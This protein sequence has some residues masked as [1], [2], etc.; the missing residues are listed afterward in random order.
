MNQKQY[1]FNKILISNR[2]EIAS[3]IIFTCKALGIKTVAI[4]SPEDK[5]M[6]YVYQADKAYELSGNGASAYLDQDEIIK[7]A[8]E[9]KV[10]AIHPGYGFF[11][12]N[13]KFAQ[14]VID[15][16]I[17]WI[18]PD[19][20]SIKLMGDKTEARNTMLK[21]NVPVIPGFCLSNNDTK[22]AQ[23]IALQIGY[24]IILKDPLGGGGKA[25]RKVEEQK[26]FESC[27]KIVKSE[28]ERFTGSN[29]IIIEK[30]IKN[31]RHIEI[32]VAGDGKNFI[33]LYERECSIQRRHQKII[34]ETPCNF[35]SKET[36][37]K[38]YQT[39]IYAAKAVNYKNI[40]T[41]E[42]IVTPDQNF[43][44]LE[45][46]TRL[47]VEHSITE[48]TTGIDLV[49]LQLEIAQ[50]GKLPF[51]Q[52]E[53][54]Q[55]SHAIECRIYSEDPG[56]NFAPSTGTIKNLQLPTGPFIRNDH[57]LEENQ[58]ITP[59]FDPMISKLTTVGSNR[60][61]A[62]KNMLN[63]LEQFNISG[64]KTNIEFLKNILKSEKFINGEFHTQ[65]LNDPEYLKNL[66][67]KSPNNPSQEEIAKIIF[68]LFK[69]QAKTKPK[70]CHQTNNNWRNQKWQ[71]TKKS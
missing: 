64:I 66:L 21:A 9:A 70:H 18:G 38:M 29:K 40:G 53:I 15:S 28:S 67:N 45:M 17:S 8:L 31:G 26:D 46:N 41:V 35:L 32:Q 61:F 44:F 65:T 30:Y 16:K 57:N 5:F 51:K 13:Y 19:P 4:Y 6:P 34:E 63:A 47:Q 25:I 20:Q 24:P 10:D 50:N 23:K 27:W 68:S 58:E 12:E 36:L 42:F 39:A 69:Q 3:R 52:N 56:N 55:K 54:I 48:S 37:E 71:W 33:H 1:N 62:I 59:F 60:D 2:S 43:Y 7:I 11:S 49:A 22:S 14:K